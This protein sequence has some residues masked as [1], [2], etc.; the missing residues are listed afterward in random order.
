L[1]VVQLD[2][3]DPKI[4]FSRV[5]TELYCTLIPFFGFGGGAFENFFWMLLANSF[6]DHGIGLTYY[7]PWY[8]PIKEKHCNIT[9]CGIVLYCSIVKI[10]WLC[11]KT[12]SARRGSVRYCCSA[13]LHF[14][15]G[16]KKTGNLCV[17]VAHQFGWTMLYLCL[18]VM[19]FNVFCILFDDLSV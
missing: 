16:N 9:V 11:E 12:V 5:C 7:F 1:L 4:L 2:I 14:Q 17:D 13:S 18:S 15:D 19:C 3:P 8:F 10:L 6:A